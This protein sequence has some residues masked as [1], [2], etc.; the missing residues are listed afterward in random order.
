MAQ[1]FPEA[2]ASA[3][4]VNLPRPPT[5]GKDKDKGKDQPI[6][7]QRVVTGASIVGADNGNRPGGFVLV[8]DGAALL[9]VRHLH[10]LA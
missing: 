4:V 9:E 3:S 8:I 10:L 1:F 6:P 2:N 5:P 7:L